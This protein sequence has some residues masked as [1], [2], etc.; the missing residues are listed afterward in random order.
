MSCH[1]PRETSLCLGGQLPFRQA[2]RAV[3]NQCHCLRFSTLGMLVHK[4]EYLLWSCE[5]RHIFTS[6]RQPEDHPEKRDW[7]ATYEE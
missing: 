4:G 1:E 7:A 5:Q 6:H 3:E 2:L